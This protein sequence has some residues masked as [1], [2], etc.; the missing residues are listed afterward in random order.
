MGREG[1]KEKG[2]ERGREVER[3]REHARVGWEGKQG[4]R[5]ATGKGTEGHGA[6]WEFRDSAGSWKS[7]LGTR[8]GKLDSGYPSA[9]SQPWTR[10]AQLS[11]STCGVKSQDL[12]FPC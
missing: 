12:T 6:T 4:K 8:A 7:P 2:R 10:P 9:G 3:E 1:G 5:K 11:P